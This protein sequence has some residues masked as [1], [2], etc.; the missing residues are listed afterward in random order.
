VPLI[1]STFA[2][3][4]L[5]RGAHVQTLLGAVLPRGKSVCYTR[6]RL[7]LAD[8]DFVDL[9][10]SRVGAD[11]LVLISHGLESASSDS[12]TRGVVASVNAAGWDAL[13]WNF[14]GCSGESNRLPRFYHSGETSDLAAVIARAARD[15]SQI[16]LVGFSL[17]GN[18]TLKYLGEAPPSGGCR[19]VCAGIAISAP[20][21]LAS[22]ARRLDAHPGNRFYLRRFL[23]KLAA[24][25][26]TKALDFPDAFDTRGLREIRSFAEFD[27]RFTAR[28]HGFRDASDYWAQSSARPL[29]PRIG[30]PTLLLSALDDPF[31]AP[32]SFPESEARKSEHVTLETPRHGGHLGFIDARGPWLERR[33]VEFLAA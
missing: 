32:E 8:G 2:P 11:R 5:L 29:L 4:V 1:N 14:R 28:L 10:W 31:L 17:G 18:M 30:I 25:V 19:T 3:P 33:I 15:H 20:I 24:K 27:D 21:D 9:D 26:E 16:A 23:R 6:E 22:S 12:L 13:A 7:E